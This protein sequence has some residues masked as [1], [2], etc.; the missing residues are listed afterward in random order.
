MHVS[1]PMDDVFEAIKLGWLPLGVPDAGRHLMF[2]MRGFDDVN[3]QL[4]SCGKVPANEKEK[5]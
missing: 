4:G 5:R 1:V 3:L 2:I